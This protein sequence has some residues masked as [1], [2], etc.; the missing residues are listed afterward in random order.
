M[1]Y[2]YMYAYDRK[3]KLDGTLANPWDGG[4]ES[5]NSLI[6]ARL[7]GKQWKSRGYYDETSGKNMVDACFSVELTV[8]EKA[9]LDTCYNDWDPDHVDA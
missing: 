2:P 3:N 1:D 9:T 7:P 8:P 5:F 6:L 4:T